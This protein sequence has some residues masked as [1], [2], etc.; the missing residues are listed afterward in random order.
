M[1]Q[2]FRKVEDPQRLL[3]RERAA[4]TGRRVPKARSKRADDAASPRLHRISLPIAAIVGAVVAA[5]L[6][7]G[8]VVAV[9]RSGGSGT[10][11]EPTTTNSLADPITSD[12]SVS[13]PPQLAPPVVSIGTTTTQLPTTT[14][15]AVTTIHL[16]SVAATSSVDIIPADPNSSSSFTGPMPTFNFAVDCLVDGCTF[17]LRTFAPGTVTD[18][19]LTTIPAVGGRFLSTSTRSVACTGSKGTRFVRNIT[20]TID[21]TLSGSQTVSGIAVPQQIGGALTSVVPE[22]GYVPHVG[23]VVDQGAERGCPGQTLVF[24]VAGDLAPTG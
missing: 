10:A 2:Y 24:T 16:T 6:V 15:P 21:L 8:A 19:G 7:I 20:N 12:A 13:K 17:S 3:P 23:E 22:A 9:S 1:T 18:A 11:T 5:L 4:V 14:V